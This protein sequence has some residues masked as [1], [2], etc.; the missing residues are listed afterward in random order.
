MHAQVYA[1]GETLGQDAT[2]AIRAVCGFSD[3]EDMRALFEGAGFAP[4]SVDTVKLDLV[5]EDAS[6]FA[7]GLMKATPVADQIAAMDEDARQALR[8]RILDG[9]GDHYDG[10]ALRFP[11]SSNVV[12]AAKPG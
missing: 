11:H 8:D 10:S 2:A 6:R 4:V 3:P 7:G 5:A 1:F 9:F 12:V